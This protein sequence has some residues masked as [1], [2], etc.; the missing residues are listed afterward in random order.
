[1]VAGADSQRNERGRSNIEESVSQTY[2]AIA[3]RK[4]N[5]DNTL[6]VRKANL[7]TKPQ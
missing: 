7:N 3:Y 2:D 4:I 5:S 6:Y 1:M